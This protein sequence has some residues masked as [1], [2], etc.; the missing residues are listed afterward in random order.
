MFPQIPRRATDVTTESTMVF[1]LQIRYMI[2]D[3]VPSH[4]EEGA[5]SKAAGCLTLVSKTLQALQ[6]SMRRLHDCKSIENII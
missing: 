5:F 1:S 2:L 4:E 3:E 6:R